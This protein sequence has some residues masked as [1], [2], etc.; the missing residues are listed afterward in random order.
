MTEENRETQYEVAWR[1]D[2]FL[3][4]ALTVA[5]IAIASVCVF[6]FIAAT[7]N[8]LLL[9]FTGILFAVLLDGMRDFV[10]RH[11]GFNDHISLALVV[12]GGVILIVGAT[13]LLGPRV[14]DQMNELNQ[15]IPKAEF[16]LRKELKQHELSREFLQFI[17]TR[18]Q[19]RNMLF[20]RS[21]RSVYTQLTGVFSTTFSILTNVVIIGFIGIY[22]AVEP[23]TYLRNVLRLI[24][25]QHQ[26]RAREVLQ[27]IGNKTKS[28][29]FSR[30]L[31]MLVVGVLVTIGLRIIGIPLAVTLGLLAGL[32]SFIPTFGPIISLIPALLVALVKSSSAALYVL[33]LYIGVQQFENYLITPLIERRTVALPPALTLSAQLIAGVVIGFIGLI[34]APPIVIIIVVSIRMLYIEDILGQKEATE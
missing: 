34:L 31:S 13:L 22:L 4:R 17:P 27:T 30:F 11:T 9:V 28:W 8:V 1:E 6:L 26:P 10:S 2:F 29:F 24:P 33:V 23:E 16:E 20:E 19:V 7:F 3:R 25:Q 32:L 5:A 15:R 18:I 12:G 14:I 21:D